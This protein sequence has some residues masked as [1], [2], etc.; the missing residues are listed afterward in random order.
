[1]IKSRSLAAAV[2]LLFASV[3]SAQ[4]RTVVFVCQYGT[5]KSLI[6]IEHFNKLARE[7]GL[8]VAA[9]SRGTRP[10]SVVPGPVRQG[11]QSDGFDI[12]FFRPRRFETSDIASAL[13]VVAIDADVHAVVG[14]ARPIVRWDGLPSVS[15]NYS[16]GRTAI[17]SRVTRLV[18]SLL[19]KPQ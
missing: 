11:L 18:D 6:A 13:L 8:N 17:V 16:A 9:V 2:T 1:V 7:R 10:D 19:A 14:G 12:A 4:E 5:V 3:G 15:A